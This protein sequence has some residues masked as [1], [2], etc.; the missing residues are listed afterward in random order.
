VSDMEKKIRLMRA[1]A[2]CLSIL[3]ALPADERPAVILALIMSTETLMAKPG[4]QAQIDELMRKAS[5]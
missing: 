3:S 4:V 5:L 2:D 1:S